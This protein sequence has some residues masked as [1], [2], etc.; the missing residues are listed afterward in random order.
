LRRAL[1]IDPRNAGSHYNLAVVADEGG[2]AATAIEH[3]RAFLRFGTVTHADL[4]GRV[5]ARLTTLG[6]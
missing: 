5:R 4:V 6:G 2:D 1:A 3:Y